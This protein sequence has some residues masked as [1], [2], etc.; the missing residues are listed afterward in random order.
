MRVPV[1]EIVDLQQI[2]LCDAEKAH[3]PLLLV[4]A[5]L[6]ATRPNFCG[7][8]RLL[9]MRLQ[10]AD[11]LLGFSVHRRGVD[12]PPARRREMI[13]HFSER[14]SAALARDVERAPRTEADDR[15]FFA[16]FGDLA[17][18]HSAVCRVPSANCICLLGTDTGHSSLRYVPCSKNAVSARLRRAISLQQRAG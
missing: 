2:N 12:D 7:N 10:L 15:D 16:A 8:E 9:H 3:G 11:R 4:V 14:N 13:E 18:L 6:S 17:V 1:D 5:R